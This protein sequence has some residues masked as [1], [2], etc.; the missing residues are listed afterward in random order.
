[1]DVTRLAGVALASALM[2]SCAGRAAP[3]AE[4]A[5]AAWADTATGAPPA[6]HHVH[7]WSRSGV[8]A[9]LEIQ[10]KVGQT[11]IP[12][13][14][15]RV[16]GADEIVAGLDSA[17]VRHA[18]LLSNAYFFGNPELDA[19]DE[20]RKVRAEN[21]YVARQVRMHPERL[22]AFFS[23]NPLA[24]YALEEMERL[25]DE[26]EFTG[27]KLHLANSDFDFRDSAQIVRLRE[28]FRRANELD[29]PVIV[30]L[31][32]R[33]E[34]FGRREVETFI[35]AVLPAAPDVPVQVA[36]LGGESGFDAGTAAAVEAFASALEEHPARTD[37]LFFDMAAVPVPAHRARGDSALLEKVRAINDR[38]AEAVREIGPDRIV[39]GTDWPVV[40]MPAYLEGLRGALPMSEKTFRDLIDDT[41]PYLP[42]EEEEGE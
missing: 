2:F 20:Y 15:A 27:L 37:R 11:V 6:D 23:V 39:Y 31:R 28:V 42:S 38:V 21:D 35:D 14:E 41:A 26:P 32:T 18:V 22:T 30:H 7:L 34:D 25:A 29:L 10:E 1:M 19:E 17:G 4:M 3:A 33:R 40:S 13:D 24:E 36:H 12:P 16:L 9:L 8:D 5:L